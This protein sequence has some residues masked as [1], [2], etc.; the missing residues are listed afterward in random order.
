MVSD[1]AIGKFVN[2]FYILI[3]PLPDGNGRV[4]RL[5]VN[6]ALIQDGYLPAIIPHPAA[7][8]APVPRGGAGRRILLL[9]GF[10]KVPPI[11]KNKQHECKGS[12]QIVRDRLCCREHGCRVKNVPEQKQYRQINKSL[13]AD[14]ENQCRQGGTGRLDCVDKYKQ[15]PHHRTR[16]DIN[17][18]K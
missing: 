13:A 10:R 2:S 6:H 14:G 18:G 9:T 16:V 5:F 11:G 1:T 4:A 15:K 8:S 7:V 12:R 17:P 3:V